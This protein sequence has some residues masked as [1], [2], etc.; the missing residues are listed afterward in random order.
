MLRP[1]LGLSNN[2]EHATSVNGTGHPKLSDFI[3][4]GEKI[5]IPKDRCLRLIEQITEN[6]HPY[7]RYKL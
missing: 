7:I 6:C 1:G 3:D 4:A 2:R 5:R